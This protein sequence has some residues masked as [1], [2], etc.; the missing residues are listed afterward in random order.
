MSIADL[1][2]EILKRAEDSREARAMEL[3]K[4]FGR[5]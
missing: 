5:K 2:R 3:K 1:N 4:A